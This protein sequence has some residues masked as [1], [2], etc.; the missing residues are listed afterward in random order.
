MWCVGVV[1]L[2]VVQAKEDSRNPEEL[3]SEKWRPIIGVEAILVS[4]QKATATELATAIAIATAIA[5]A[6]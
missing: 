1:P 3:M 4:V 6:I 2:S 5:T